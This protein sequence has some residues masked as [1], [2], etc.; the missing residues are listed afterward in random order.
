MDIYRRLVTNALLLRT[1][2]PFGLSSVACSSKSVD[3]SQVSELDDQVEVENSEDDWT[4]G[5]FPY[6]SKL[7][8]ENFMRYGKQTLPR[9]QH[10]YVYTGSERLPSLEER[11]KGRF[12]LLH[13]Y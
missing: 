11:L 13:I 5:Q 8:K 1:R 7:V 10:D 12:L 9:A 4:F 6:T 2:T 3:G